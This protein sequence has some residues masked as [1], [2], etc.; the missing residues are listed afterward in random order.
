M[1]HFSAL[2]QLAL[3]STFVAP[4]FAALYT[5][6]SQLPTHVYDYIIVGGEFLLY[7][8]HKS[9]MLRGHPA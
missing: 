6:P 9:E 5:T 1:V 2:F 8:T 4:S 7:L 3:A